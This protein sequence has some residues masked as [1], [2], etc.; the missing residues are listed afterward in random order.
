MIIL[1]VDPGSRVTGYGLIR[2]EGNHLRCLEYGGIKAGDSRS[3]F[4]PNRLKKIYGELYSI[5]ARYSPAV[6]VVEDIF[7]AA[8]A[9]SALKLGH[10]RGVVLLVGAQLEIPLVEYSPLQVK[11]AVVGYGRADKAQIQKM[12]QTLLKLKE[13]PL[14]HDA[15]DALA[16]ALCHAFNGSLARHTRPHSHSHR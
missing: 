15:A 12:V 10:T 14:S 6:M 9:Q 8:N 13:K 2:C 3:T 1:G 7:C 5:T 16:V 11:K 4:S